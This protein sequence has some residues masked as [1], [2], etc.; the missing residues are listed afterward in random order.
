MS[1]GEDLS[2]IC[3]LVQCVNFAAEKHKEQR[4]KDPENTPYINHPIGN[5]LRLGYALFCALV[6]FIIFTSS[7]SLS[8]VDN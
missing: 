7:I 2:N 4:R 1:T 6:V 8:S 5:E 3:G